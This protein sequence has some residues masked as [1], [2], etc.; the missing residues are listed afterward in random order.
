MRIIDLK[1]RHLEAF[2]DAYHAADVKD[3]LS[4]IS[5]RTVRAAIAAGWFGEGCDADVGEMK[6]GEVR[7]L[8]QEINEAYT[9]AVTIDPN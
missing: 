7:Q 5:G 6:A 9:A 2:E 1:Q 8:A 4:N 3:G